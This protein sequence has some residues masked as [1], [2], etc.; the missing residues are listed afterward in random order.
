M[1]AVAEV[2]S[3][4]D[5]DEMEKVKRFIEVFQSLKSKC[6]SSVV[7]VSVIIIGGNT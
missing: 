4:L 2:T 5:N 6:S 7:M 1:T 3:F